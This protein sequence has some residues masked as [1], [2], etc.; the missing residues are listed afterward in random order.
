MLLREGEINI[1]RLARESHVNYKKLEKALE[2]LERKNIIEIYEGD[3][4]KLIRI[5]YSNPKVIIL[6]NLFDELE[7]I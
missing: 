5:N 7:S 6:K 4:T 3:K 2:T 1:T